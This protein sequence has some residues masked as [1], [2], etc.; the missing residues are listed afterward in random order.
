MSLFNGREREK[1]E[2]IELFREVDERL[3]LEN[4]EMPKGAAHGII[5]ARWHC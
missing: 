2:W 4:L 5:V 3:M 1:D